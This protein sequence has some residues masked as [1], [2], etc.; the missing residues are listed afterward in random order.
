MIKK[1]NSNIVLIDDNY[2]DDDNDNSNIN[3][4]T[5]CYKTLTFFDHNNVHFKTFL[6]IF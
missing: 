6:L 4:N 3:I 2:E 1:K 5:D